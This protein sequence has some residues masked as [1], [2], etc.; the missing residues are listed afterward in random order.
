MV[1]PKKNAVTNATIDELEANNA[2]PEVIA[3]YEKQQ[4]KNTNFEV[5]PENW[6]TIEF[7][8]EVSTQWKMGALGGYIG[9]DYVSIDIDIRRSELKVTKEQWC[10]MKVMESAAI[11][12]LN[13]KDG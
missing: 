1:R 7:W 9:L 13:K 3:I 11:R 6:P 2:P 4:R 5:W 12:I 10:G 8:L